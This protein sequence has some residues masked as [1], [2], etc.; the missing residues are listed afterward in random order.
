MAT[1]FRHWFYFGRLLVWRFNLTKNAD[2]DEPSCSSYGTGFDA[3]GYHSL[4]DGSVGKNVAIFGVDMSST[5]HIDNKGKDI[6][7]LGKG[8]TQG[9]NHT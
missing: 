6:L 9:S 5:V 2:P 4:P 7:N 8:P 1:R 3:C